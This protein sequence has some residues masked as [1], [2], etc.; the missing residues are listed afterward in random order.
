[1]IMALQ[2]RRLLWLSWIKGSHGFSVQFPYFSPSRVPQS[3]AKEHPEGL[4]VGLEDRRSENYEKPPPPKY[5]EFSGTGT[6]MSK[7]QTQPL[8]PSNPDAAEKPKVDSALISEKL[9]TTLGW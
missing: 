8:G 1:M 6:V 2:R 9:T 7:G 3:L 4:D 5:V